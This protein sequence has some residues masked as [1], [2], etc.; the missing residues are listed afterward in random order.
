MQKSSFRNA[1]AAKVTRDSKQVWQKQDEGQPLN[2][3]KCLVL[4][5]KKWLYPNEETWKGTEELRTVNY[6]YAHNILLTRVSA[7]AEGHQQPM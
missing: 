2:C 4:Y 7:L 1:T 6:Y 5:E 3:H